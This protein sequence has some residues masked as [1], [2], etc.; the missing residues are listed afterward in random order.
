MDQRAITEEMNIGILIMSE[1]D[2]NQCFKI[3]LS[4]YGKGCSTIKEVH[5]LVNADIPDQMTWN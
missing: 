4:K 1:G 5:I 3:H 2:P